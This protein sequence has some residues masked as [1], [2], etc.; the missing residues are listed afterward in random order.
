MGGAKGKGKDGGKG[1]KG[2]GKG[3][4]S[5]GKSGD[6][7][8]T[9]VSTD[10]PGKGGKPSQG[11]STKGQGTKGQ[12]GKKPNPAAPRPVVN[13]SAAP[14]PGPSN[15]STGEGWALFAAIEKSRKEAELAGVVSADVPPQVSSPKSAKPPASSTKAKD[16]S[17]GNTNSKGSGKGRSGK[18]SKKQSL[19]EDSN[20]HE[21]QKQ[22]QKGASAAAR[23]GKDA[24][25]AEK[26]S[27][28]NKPPHKMKKTLAAEPVEEAATKTD[29][30]TKTDD[31][32]TSELNTKP[33]EAQQPATAAIGGASGYRY[34]YAN[35]PSLP[36]GLGGPP[37][38]PTEQTGPNQPVSSIQQPP[39]LGDQI[40]NEGNEG[41]QQIVYSTADLLQVAGSKEA[42]QPVPDLLPFFRK[43]NPDSELVHGGLPQ[44]GDLAAPQGADA[45]RIKE[46][47]NDERALMQE[48]AD[49]V[50]ELEDSDLYSHNQVGAQQAENY[51]SYYDAHNN[52]NQ[53]AAAGG[54][55][56]GGQDLNFASSLLASIGAVLPAGED[57]GVGNGSNFLGGTGTALDTA[58]LLDPAIVAASGAQQ[59]A[60]SPHH[61]SD[62]NRSADNSLSPRGD[63]PG[64]EETKKRRR[65][66]CRGGGG[67]R[68]HT[69][70]PAPL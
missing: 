31:G 50:A 23:N 44:G 15:P 52:V 47:L 12:A 29:S 13:N 39:G 33:E 4:G 68:P 24:K 69:T 20:K 22:E 37:G 7:K 60:S 35:A 26:R 18:D 10:K 2:S 61:S 53:H 46:Q 34:G 11:Q 67:S 62:R 21:P 56:A 38:L 30:A 66:P 6:A 65:S 58:A 27:R 3:K 63:R 14:A 28:R 64:Q 48:L 49:E 41:H 19:L 57:G 8:P 43:D 40:E 9:K 25:T 42:N 59:V 32:S 45:R 55:E 17:S 51:S 16:A 36:P 5:G 54:Q 70:D 1:A